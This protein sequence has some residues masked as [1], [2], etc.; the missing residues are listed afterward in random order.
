[1]AAISSDEEPQRARGELLCLRVEGEFFAE[2]E[3]LV[4]LRAPS[5]EN[6]ERKREFEAERLQPWFGR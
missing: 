1:V 3:P 4:W 6:A 5:A 2:P